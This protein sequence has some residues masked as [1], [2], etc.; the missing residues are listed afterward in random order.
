MRKT[1]IS[2]LL[3][4]MTIPMA[5]ANARAKGERV[6]LFDGKT[7]KGWTVLKC[8]AE[9][10][11][12]NMLIKSGNGLVQTEKKYGDFVL[13]FECKALKSD[14][15]DS[16]VYF[17][18]DKV[19]A[20]RPWPG[21]YQVNLRK[22][23][24][25][26]VGGVKGAAGKGLYK[27]GQWNTF[28]LTV[29]GTKLA[30][31][32]NG[33]PAWKATGLAGPKEGF[34]SVQAEVPHGGQFLFR[35]IYI[36]TKTSSTEEHAA[37]G[38][39]GL[40][41]M[42]NGKDLTGWKTTGNWIVE[43]DNT[44]ALH[45]RPGEHGWTRYDAYLT[46]DRKYK[47]FILDLEFKFKKGGNSG[48]FLR[49]GDPKSQVNSGF[50]VQ[51]LDTHGK[52]KFGAHDCGGVIGTAAPSKMMVKPAGEWNRYTIT[53]I[54]QQLKVVLNGEQVIDLDLSKSRLK[55]RPLA[56]YIGFQ[57]EGKFVWYRNVRIKEI[58]GKAKPTK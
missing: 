32:M 26:N 29:E 1:S 44:V 10:Q 58:T 39:D 57:D 22:G 50:E 5:F 24:E 23:M 25:G 2:I 21:R 31:E 19:P 47:D 40:R 18:Y 3:A 34:I 41:P 11:E 36:S 16:G 15:W 35:N 37:I 48:V 38:E 28:K 27:A 54:G 45:P 13:E 9:V 7:L 46:T 33:K 53:C 55:D 30:L 43:K 42:F 4:A 12:G 20:N 8:Q 56:G 14:Q 6:A 52:K 51:I 17:R 49:V